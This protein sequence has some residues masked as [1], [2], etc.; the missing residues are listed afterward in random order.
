MRLAK[1]VIP[2]LGFQ[3]EQPMSCVTHSLC[4][5]LRERAVGPGVWYPAR[6]DPLSRSS[7]DARS[8]CT[9]LVVGGHLFHARHVHQRLQKVAE[10]EGFHLAARLF[11]KL[12]DHAHAAPHKCERCLAP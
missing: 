8:D 2:P 12:V 10:R 4:T 3:L 11:T 1:L 9:H 6:S 5:H 7:Q